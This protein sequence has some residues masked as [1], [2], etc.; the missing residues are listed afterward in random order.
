M[1]GFASISGGNGDDALSGG[2]GPDSMSGH[3]GDDTLLG[4]GGGDL[5]FAGTGNDEV[6]GQ[7]GNDTIAGEAGDDTLD[8]G[9]ASDTFVFQDGFGHDLIMGFT[10]GADT[11]QIEAGINGTA[12]ASPSDLLPLLSSD[13]FG[14]AVL[15]LGTDTITFQGLTVGDVSA[16]IAS[17]A[18]IV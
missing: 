10:V 5:V 17:I 16:N 7:G 9:A 12:V 1:S 15:T 14:N 11:L 4:G 8:G 6:D 18:S 3:G 13:G 2:G